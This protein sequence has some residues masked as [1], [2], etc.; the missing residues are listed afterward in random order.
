MQARVAP[1][2]ARPRVPAAA[3]EKLRPPRRD[4]VYP[5][6]MFPAEVLELQGSA[7]NGA[8]NRMLLRMLLKDFMRPQAMV[9]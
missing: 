4:E 5:G 7:G 6:S 8:V 1:Q 9:P 3:A 2:K